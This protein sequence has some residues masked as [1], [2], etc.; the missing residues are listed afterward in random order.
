[1]TRCC[2]SVLILIV[3]DAALPQWGPGGCGPVGPF[4]VPAAPAN[5]P[6]KAETE[7]FG[8]DWSKINGKD[9][10][11]YWLTI[12]GKRRRVSKWECEQILERKNLVDDSGKLRLTIIGSDAQRK[13]V[14]DALA[15]IPA[16]EQFLVQDYAPD[17]WA[18]RS[19]GFDCDGA[20]SI[21]LQLP[22]G[23]VLHR[24]ASFLG[25]DQLASA[26]DAAVHLAGQ[27]RRPDPNYDPKKDPDILKKPAVPGGD[28]PWW[29]VLG[30]G[31]LGG[32]V[33]AV[34]V[35]IGGRIIGAAAS[36]ARWTCRKIAPCECEEEKPEP[37]KK[38][39]K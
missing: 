34:L 8:V 38:R 22:D 3:P 17:H 9:G 28:W 21:Y 18:V 11:E 14:L 30:V 1:M 5:P 35:M 19:V 29:A 36:A 25:R 23:R 7:N 6:A 16:R 32:L 33:V 31:L 10:P 12:D 20:P 13:P 24:Q 2:L 27:L 26:M 15:A 4:V 37:R 39:A